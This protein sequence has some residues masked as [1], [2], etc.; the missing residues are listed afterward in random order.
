MQTGAGAANGWAVEIEHLDPQGFLDE[1]GDV[2]EQVV[3]AE[4]GSQLSPADPTTTAL[5]PSSCGAAVALSLTRVPRWPPAVVYADSRTALR[6]AGSSSPASMRLA[7]IFTTLDMSATG[8]RRKSV[9]RAVCTSE[10]AAPYQHPPIRSDRK[11]PGEQSIE[12][13]R[14]AQANERHAA[15]ATQGQEPRLER[16]AEGS[17]RGVPHLSFPARAISTSRSTLRPLFRS[18]P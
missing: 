1:K 15:I 10:R 14:L 9:P 2:A 4:R 13:D 8:I 17:R 18:L 11:Q 12:G 7:D 5:Q 3:R 6:T 16:P